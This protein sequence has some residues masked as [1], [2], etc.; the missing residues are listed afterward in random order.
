MPIH[1]QFRDFQRPG[2]QVAVDY[3]VEHFGTPDGLDL[4]GIVLAVPT[5]RA[6]RRVLELLVA[7]AEADRVP[8]CPPEI[9]TVGNL[10]EKL[11]QAKRPFADDLTQQLAW[12]D[13]LRG[14]EPAV[15]ERLIPSLPADDDFPAWLAL[16]AMLAGLHRELAREN[17]NFSDVVEAGA[18]VDGFRE[19]PR[20]Q[21]L[22]QV[23][24]RYLGILDSLGLWDQQTA[25]RVAIRDN[26]CMTDRPILLVGTAD[27]NRQ[28]RLMLDQVAD[29]VTALV[30]A[31]ESL[32]DRFDEHGC[33]KPDAWLEAPIDFSDEQI[34]Q[35]DDPAG[36][37]AA[38]G[39]WLAGLGAR[40]PA[41]QIT[42]G[43]PDRVADELVP[44]LQQL[45][46]ACG[47]PARYGVGRPV[48]QSS[49]CR[50]LTAVAEYLTSRSFAALAAL[51]RHP[52]LADWV[53][54]Q[55]IR[56]DWLSRLDAYQGE[57]LPAR[58]DKSGS[59][60]GWGRQAASAVGRR[61]LGQRSSDPQRENGDG[62]SL[63]RPTKNSSD[64]DPPYE[65]V[66]AQLH[67]AVERLLG[68]LADKHTLADW[69]K[70]VLELLAAVFGCR[71]LDR[72]REPDRSILRACELIRDAAR[73]NAGIPSR[74]A[75]AVAGQVAAP[76]ALHMLLGQLEADRIS[77]A[78]ERGAVEMLGWLDLPLDDAPAL[79]VTG[80]NEGAVPD[81]INADLFLPNQLRRALGIMDND[82]R[83]AR[84]AYVLSVLAASRERLAL[85]TGRR[86]AVGD[87]LAPSRLLFAC[88][89]ETA[90]RRAG[91]FFAESEATI[92]PAAHGALRAG[93][94]ASALP[95]PKPDPL[96]EPVTSM[97]VTEFRDYLACPY[98]YYLRHRL[99]L[100]SLADTAQ[101][102]DGGGF[103]SLAHDVL[104]EFARSPAV[105]STDAEEIEAHLGAALDRLA[106][107]R[108]GPAAL[109][110]VRV[111][112][113]QLRWRLRAFARWQAGWAA[114]GWRIQHAE[115]SPEPGTAVL[116]VDGTP[117]QLRGRID[118]IDF[119]PAAKEYIVFDYKTSESARAPEKTHRKQG[120]WID[121]QLPLYRHLVKG[122]GI[123]DSVRL[124]YIALPK[125]T[126][127]V[128]IL[129]AEW[130]DADLA[131]A[132]AAAAD[133]IRGVRA[134]VFWPPTSPPPAFSEDLAAICQDG[135]YGAEL[136]EAEG[137][138]A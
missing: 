88:D 123:S 30:F 137:D 9:V 26:E 93:Q 138:A 128:G 109:P 95:V 44:Q 33:L 59:P 69:G 60:V 3:L 135:Q 122:L 18:A 25:R 90:A 4:A 107:A 78:P 24:K 100:E 134:G 22:V 35:A 21:A 17:V 47:V 27:L 65:H 124:A 63:Q 41:E 11:Y 85:V 50:L 71:P 126:N 5:S 23:Q 131:E 92:G 20:W 29:H 79:I 129:P 68:P 28:Q 84:D 36:Q 114:E 118:R 74:L 117:M 98:R 102:L 75:D 12:I 94:A 58:L 105:H 43:V 15:V 14:S 119:N 2:L 7:R 61:S 121:L 54:Q 82:R 1:S 67:A 86:S 38:V 81:A 62:S 55:G 130:T 87:P 64:L 53:V 48:A 91:R 39:R 113:E 42:I 133:V 8:L 104:H 66:V 115:A 10:P 6:G 19:T 125:D 31:P 111:Q 49:P 32:A 108:F 136:A 96:P 51:V 77:A 37:A 83:Y 56:G 120:E 46:T 40:Y 52:A 89:D 76:E 99:K 103:G 57:R 73:E 13:A 45:L 80:F 16:G 101:E 97:R 34:V 116:I 70:P 110:A 112:I 132:D 106:D 72:R 127:A